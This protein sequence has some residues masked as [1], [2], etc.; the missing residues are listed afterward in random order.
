MTQQ[1]IAVVGGAASIL[2]PYLVLGHL[3]ALVCCMRVVIG[4][5][6]FMWMGARDPE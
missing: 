2:T 5:H 6:S 4:L 3:P 1:D